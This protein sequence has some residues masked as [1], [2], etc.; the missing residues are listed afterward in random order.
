MGS[1]VAVENSAATI[2]AASVSSAV[3]KVAG[4]NS[5]VSTSPAGD[6]ATAGIFVV[7]I[8]VVSVSASVFFVQIIFIE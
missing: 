5:A 1:D 7:I 6:G 4:I 2:A 3:C 8:V